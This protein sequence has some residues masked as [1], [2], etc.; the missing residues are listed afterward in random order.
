MVQD[1]YLGGGNFKFGHDL[2]PH[3]SAV[4]EKQRRTAVDLAILLTG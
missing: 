3:P 4:K 2:L 1:E